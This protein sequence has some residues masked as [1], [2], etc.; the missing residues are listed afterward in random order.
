MGGVAVFDFDGTV[1]RGDSI[2]AMIAFARRRSLVRA[3]EML[4]AAL[5]GV[6]YH[7]RLKDAL[8]AKRAGHAFLTRMEPKA[9]GAFLDEFA[10]SL[11]DRAY[12][13]ALRQM[14][15]HRKAGDKVLLCSASGACYMTRVARLLG[16]DVL[17]CTP[18]A[19]NGDVAG[20]NCRGQE[21][22]R[23]VE[24]WLAEQ[25]LSR[26]DICAAYGD[27]AGDAPVLRMSRHPV[28]VNA[29]RGLVKKLPEAERV[30]WR[31]KNG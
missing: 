3:P 8:A 26:G 15:I 12:P 7:V 4:R 5:F 24:A 6:L 28:L 9:R 23:R 29:K 16:A 18:C 10:K 11:A 19:E 13:D 25:G 14:E 17:L 31:E 21:K 20:P 22:V 27:S 2:V 30:A 1:I